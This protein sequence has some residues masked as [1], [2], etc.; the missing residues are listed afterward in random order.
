LHN[1]FITANLQ[2]QIMSTK[3]VKIVGNRAVVI[4]NQGAS[5]WATLYVNARNGI[6]SADI[7][8]LRWSGST[9]AGALR[10]ADKQLAV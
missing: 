1:S 2:R 3:V 7:T 10:W 4:N 9:M 8:S 6:E 5:V